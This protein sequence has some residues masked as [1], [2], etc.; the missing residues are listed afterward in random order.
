MKYHINL[1]QQFF[2]QLIALYTQVV[3]ISI[4]REGITKLVDF[5]KTDILFY[6]SY[7]S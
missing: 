2:I 1:F 7:I 3:Q 5:F 4:A 6:F